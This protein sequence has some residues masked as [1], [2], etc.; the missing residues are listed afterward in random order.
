MFY[1]ILKHTHSG[2]RWVALLLLVAAIV[3]AWQTW[4]SGRSGAGKLPLF[5]LITAHVQLLLGLA[6]Y[7]T[8]PHVQFTDGFMK[9]AVLRFYGVEHI[10]V[11]LLALTAITIGYSRAKRQA[12]AADSAKVIFRFYTIALVLILLGIPWPFRI[13]VAGWF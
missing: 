8:S 4:K 2:L 13:P 5:A 10:T 7:F 9:D 12:S 11:M 3:T 6:L 1:T